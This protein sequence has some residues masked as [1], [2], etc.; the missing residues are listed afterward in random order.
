MFGPFQVPAASNHQ[1]WA[2][3]WIAFLG[4]NEESQGKMM[5]ATGRIPAHPPTLRKIGNYLGYA[6]PHVRDYLLQVTEA[7]M[8]ADMYPHTLTQAEGAIRSFF[9]A[10]FSQVL[11]GMQPLETF[12]ETMQ[13]QIQIELDK[14][15]AN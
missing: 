7:S 2:F 1:E 9:D 4:M 11:N 10:A 14:L 12:L 5:E 15:W 3:R 6:E 13:T 8:H